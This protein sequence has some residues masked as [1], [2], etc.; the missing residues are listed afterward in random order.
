MLRKRKRVSSDKVKEKGKLRARDERD[1]GFTGTL[2][3]PSA[4]KV[5]SA[6]F[7][8]VAFSEVLIALA[9]YGCMLGRI[10]SVPQSGGG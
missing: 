5:N 7:A 9:N 3:H 8:L 2:I 10:L 1:P 4:W 6:N